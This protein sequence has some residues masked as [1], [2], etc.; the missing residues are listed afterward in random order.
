M[1]VSEQQ[2]HSIVETDGSNEWGSAS[3]FREILACARRATSAHAYLSEALTHIGRAFGSPFASIYARS[4]SEV[5]EDETH[6]G[7]SDPGFW[8]PAV[9][10]FLTD[11][12]T[13]D[14]PRARVLNARNAA[15]KV[16][17][18]SA[19]LKSSDGAINGAVAVVV[20]GGAEEA[21]AHLRMLEALVQ[22]TAA[23]IDTVGAPA[24]RPDTVEQGPNKT[25]A[26]AAMVS[27]VEELAFAI[28]N[29]LR[30]KLGCE[31]VALGLASKRHVRVVSI[32]GQ[33]EVKKRSPGVAQLQDAME[34]CLD[35]G[36]PIVCQ[37]D[38]AWDTETLTVGFRLHQQWQRLAGGASV[39][40]I[41]L[42]ADERCV[43]ILSMRRRA[44][45]PFKR[46]QIDEVRKLI[47]PF[48]PALLLVRDAKRGLLTHASN[49]VFETAGSFLRPGHLGR[50]IAGAVAAAA[51]AWFC[52]GTIDY[53]LTVSAVLTP[54]HQRHVAAPFDAAL[55]SASVV[56]GD[57]VREG[58]VLCEFDQRELN[59]RRDELR[60]QLAVLERER[61]RAMAA[62]QPV[63]AKLVEAN[64]RLAR[65]QLAIAERRIEQAVLRAPFD[66]V[67]ITGDLR[68]QIG[69]VMAQG[70]PL[71]EIAPLDSW[72]L[73]MDVPEGVA[74]E[75]IAGLDAAGGARAFAGRFAG[76]ARPEAAEPFEL[77]RVRPRVEIKD[78]R[79][80]FIAEA[81][82][83]P[84]AEWM[85]PGMEGV[86]KINA[87]PRRVWWVALH[88]ALDQLRMNYWL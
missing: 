14:C 17:L 61:L 87:G 82:I 15:L 48:A 12:L 52:F 5:I 68:K 45:E 71:F 53:E 34:E 33:D 60:S 57:I 7:P 39:A 32:S 4:R 70:A 67:V 3:P 37:N 83:T 59:L 78:G 13:E 9:Q 74:G 64:Q 25:L 11:S 30:A 28:T 54:A 77:T 26:R 84:D 2:S 35:L 56:A 69:A 65:V 36:E 63:E 55:A 8:R 73:E 46:E 31:M 43:A 58:D 42:C 85:R 38:S 16:S 20:R 27:S 80:V 41:P 6:C 21:S 81:D 51:L 75:L 79:N 44:N 72:T 1:S 23:A 10:R 50:K 19:P 49:A 88:R 40:S 24:R 47:E 29:N 18:L 66:G 86:A 76:S 62:N 22:L